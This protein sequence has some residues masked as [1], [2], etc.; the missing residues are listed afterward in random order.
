M[1]DKMYVDKKDFD[2]EELLKEERKVKKLVEFTF[3]T[4]NKEDAKQTIKTMGKIIKALM[5]KLDECNEFEAELIEENMRLYD[6]NDGYFIALKKVKDTLEKI[7]D[8]MI[9]LNSDMIT[10]FLH[11]SILEEDEDEESEEEW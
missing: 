5:E 10:T 7:T 1:L 3:T 4:N 9:E 8:N 6:E 11:G 2:F